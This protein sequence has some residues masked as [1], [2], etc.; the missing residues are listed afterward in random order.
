MSSNAIRK[1]LPRGKRPA[2]DAF[3]GESFVKTADKILCFFEYWVNGALLIVMSAVIFTQIVCR[4][5]GLPLYWSEEIGRFI[6]IWIIYIAIGQAAREHRHLS[7]DI[8]PLLLGERGKLI[9]RIVSN[10]LC[11]L[12]FATLCY[13]GVKILGRL[14]MRPQRSQAMQLNMFYVYAVPYFGAFLAT[15]RYILDTIETV[16]SLKNIKRR[17]GA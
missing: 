11:M 13:Y 8:L 17:P 5:F 7:V 3:A 15:A 2:G 16:I 6:F 9:I 4:Q 1:R 10:I 14:N 12:F